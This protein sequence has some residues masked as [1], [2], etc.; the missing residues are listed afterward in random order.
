MFLIILFNRSYSEVAAQPSLLVRAF[1]HRYL[2][3]VLDE[4]SEIV[5]LMKDFGCSAHWSYGRF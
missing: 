1:T 5:V 3:G 4:S 2:D